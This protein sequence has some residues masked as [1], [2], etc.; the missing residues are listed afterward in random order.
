MSKKEQLDIFTAP[1]M[2][3]GVIAAVTGAKPGRYAIYKSEV[4]QA[5]ATMTVTKADSDFINFHRANPSVYNTLVRLARDLVSRGYK[6][7]GMKMIWE[8]MRWEH[9]VRT[10]DPSGSPFLLNNNLHS[11]YARL[12]MTSERDLAGIFETRR[13]KT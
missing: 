3:L 8:V 2:Q 7:V 9:M 13:L 11:R 12:M 4:G 5:V 1:P 10:T 6:R